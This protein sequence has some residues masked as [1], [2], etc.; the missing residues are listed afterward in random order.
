MHVP[1]FEFRLIKEILRRPQTQTSSVIFL[2]KSV[3]DHENL[4]MNPVSAY[5]AFIISYNVELYLDQT[6][7]YVWGLGKTSSLLQISLK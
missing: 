2:N 6:Y 7:M 1:I 4:C 3:F 5:L